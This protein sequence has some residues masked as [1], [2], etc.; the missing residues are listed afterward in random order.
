MVK[1]TLLFNKL[2][3]YKKGSLLKGQ[4]FSDQHLLENQ[5]SFDDITQ[6]ENAENKIAEK[7][8]EAIQEVAKQKSKKKKITN[9]L[10]FA[11]NIVVVAVILIQQLNQGE[12]EPFSNIIASGLF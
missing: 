3:R 7:M 2:K 8:G 12:V 1:K 9:A 4:F 6:K 5:I 11:L 10:F